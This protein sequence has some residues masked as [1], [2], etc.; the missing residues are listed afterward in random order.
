VDN[1]MQMLSIPYVIRSAVGGTVRRLGV[2]FVSPKS[3][4]QNGLHRQ[5]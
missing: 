5:I 4:C 3:D 1:T 2:F